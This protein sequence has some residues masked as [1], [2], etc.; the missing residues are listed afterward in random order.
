MTT[1]KNPWSN[2]GLAFTGLMII[3]LAGFAL[4]AVLANELAESGWTG[5]NF[6]QAYNS[7][8]GALQASSGNEFTGEATGWLFGMSGVPVLIDLISRTVLRY[9]PMGETSKSFIRRIN[10][11][12]KKYLLPLHTWLSLL[13][14]GLGILHLALSSCV[15][16]PLPELGLILSGI[17]VTTGLLYKWKA[18]PAS[19]RKA[20]YQFHASLIV[21]GV[22]LAILFTGHAVMSSD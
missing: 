7:Y 16:N 15:A 11:V 4:L 3:S 10:T 22:L 13:A 6:M 1:N 21:S 14:L 18:V 12:Q 17:L 2:L 19:I 9:A 20:L 8:R 5:P